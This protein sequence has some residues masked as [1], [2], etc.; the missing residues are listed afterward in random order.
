M[1]EASDITIIDR[2]LK[3]GLIKGEKGGHF[4]NKDSTPVTSLYLVTLVGLAIPY[5]LV[6]V[7]FCFLLTEV[8]YIIT[9]GTLRSG[10]FINIGL[11]PYAFCII[12]LVS[13]S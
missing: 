7:F 3:E 12:S 11:T 5:L 9:W 8:I 1:V 10:W 2:L 6:E 4:K 13:T